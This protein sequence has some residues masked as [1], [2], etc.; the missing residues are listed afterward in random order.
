[1]SLWNDA[2]LAVAYSRSDTLLLELTNWIFC[3]QFCDAIGFFAQRF[4]LNQ[5][6]AAVLSQRK[7]AEDKSTK[8]CVR[9]K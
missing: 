2:V 7:M 9:N 6:E 8:I 4:M 5:E 1:M 3:P